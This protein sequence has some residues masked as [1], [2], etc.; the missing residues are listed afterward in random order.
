MASTHS[1][2]DLVR[3]QTMATAVSNEACWAYV[4]RPQRLAEITAVLA[5]TLPD[6]R[7]LGV[8]SACLPGSCKDYGRCVR[9]EINPPP[10]PPPEASAPEPTPAARMSARAG[11]R[12]RKTAGRAGRDVRPPQRGVR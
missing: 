6:L 9:C 5:E 12:G 11:A 4:S 8:V 2:P 10:P 1:I 7:T 3:I